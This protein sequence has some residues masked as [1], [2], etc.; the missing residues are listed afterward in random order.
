MFAVAL[1]RWS[2]TFAIEDEVRALAPL[3][4][5]SAYDVRLALQAPPPIV[6]S[7]TPDLEAAK[8][9][10]AALRARGHGAVACDLARVRGS[11]DMFAPKTFR[12]EA[13]ELVVAAPSVEQRLP[14]GEMLALIRARH[15]SVDE[16]VSEHR[17]TKFS[18]ARAAITGGLSVTKTTVRHE[19]RVSEEREHVLY[20]FDRSGDGHVFL[21]EQRLGY[22]GLGDRLGPTTTENFA[23]TVAVLRERAASALY[24]ERLVSRRRRGDVLSA[25]TGGSSTSN[26]GETDLLAHLIA[27]A[28]LQGQL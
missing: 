19:R 25:S 2:E 23:A 28:H 9:L 12:F 8:R 5:K 13:A 14:Y 11:S 6:L 10:L 3:L 21:R 1:C 17:S 22:A 27:V 16:R 18:L 7:S 20:V 15:D 26:A 24:D 4:G